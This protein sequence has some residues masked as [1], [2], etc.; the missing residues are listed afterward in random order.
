MDHSYYFYLG[1]CNLQLNKFEDAKSFFEKSIAQSVKE[2]GE[3]ASYVVLGFKNA[4]DRPVRV[5]NLQESENIIVIDTDGYATNLS[6]ASGNPDNIT[7]PSKAGKKQSFH[8]NI[9]AATVK[10]VRIMGNILSK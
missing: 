4:N 8:F 6:L 7:I 9:A 3:N 2:D 1:L 5:I 10:E